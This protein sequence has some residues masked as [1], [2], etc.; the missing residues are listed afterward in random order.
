VDAASH[1]VLAVLL[2]HGNKI[3]AVAAAHD[4]SR[5]VA[6]SGS[7]DRSIVAWNLEALC[8]LR[9]RAKLPSEVAAVCTVPPLPCLAVIALAS[10]LI[11]SWNWRTGKLP[12]K[13]PSCI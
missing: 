7:K 13:W 3:T 6:L 10:G 9:K 5:P 8:I 12:L 1:A 11:V 4:A 2:G